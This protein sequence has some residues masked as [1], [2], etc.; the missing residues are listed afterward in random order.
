MKS[1]IHYLVLGSATLL[2]AACGGGSSSDK[3]AAEQ[4][5]AASETTTAAAA[6][7]TP[8]AATSAAAPTADS[9]DTLDGTTLAS[10]TGD[11]VHGKA[12]FTQCQACHSAE[13]GKNMI[14]PSLA[15]VVGRKAGQIAGFAYSNANKNSGITWT[16]E[17]LFQYLE[18]PQ[19]VVP[20]TKMTF[21]G[22]PKAQDRADVIAYLKN[23]T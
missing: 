12:I 23:P 22:L 16:A 13:P 21:A 8:A 9:T 5:P 10:L 2:L 14:G 18:K 4:A 20:G 19:R 3:S 11:A 6:A 1:K 17:K 7:M 15:G